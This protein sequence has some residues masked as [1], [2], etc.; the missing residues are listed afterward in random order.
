ML[1]ASIPTATRKE[2]YRRD[3]YR[4]AL[5]DSPKGLQIHHAVH[6]SEGGSN[7]PQNLICLCWKC[8]AA[9]HGSRVVINAIAD[10]KK[11]AA[12][13]D[14]YLGGSGVLNKGEEIDIPVIPV[15]DVAE[16]KRFPTR[17]LGVADRVDNFRE[18]AQGYHNLDAMAECLRCLHCDRR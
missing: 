17:T 5:C 18:V 14:R 11:A 3:G 6:R 12:G 16:H 8:H 9:A 4:C 13:I 2:V 7:Q 10:G 1:S 15:G